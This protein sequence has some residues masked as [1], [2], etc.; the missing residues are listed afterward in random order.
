MGGRGTISTSGDR[1]T[2]QG[3][4]IS[5]IGGAPD[6]RSDIQKSFVDELGFKEVLG[7]NRI[8][9]AT[10]NSYAIA[11]KGLEK[12]YGA[13]AA[14]D[15]PV[16]ATGNG[17]IGNSAIAAVYFNPAHPSDQK[18]VINS[19]YLSSTSMNLATLRKGES[20]GHFSQTDG[21][22]TRQNAYAVTHEYGHMLENALASQSGK[23][24]AS[25]ESSARSQIRNIAQTK[26][27]A[28]STASSKYGKENSAEFFAEAFASL[29]SGN[30][31]AY[32]KAMGD[33]LK[34]NKLK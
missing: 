10:L 4:N 16:F 6:K 7:T 14:S 32:G 34:S 5:N 3:V 11:L 25:Y 8:P 23:S 2:Q 22:I 21:K 28:A 9:T 17:P 1:S 33:W 20:T 12:E 19:N 15:N 24:L 27:G 26:Y 30:P 13:I 18:M 31:D 29:H